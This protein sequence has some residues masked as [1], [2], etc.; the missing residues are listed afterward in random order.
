MK[1]TIFGIA[2]A[3][4][5]SACVSTQHRAAADPA[6]SAQAF[7]MLKSLA[8]SWSGTSKMGEQTTT[9]DVSYEVVSAGSVVMERLFVGTPHEMISMYHRDGGRLLMTHYCSQGNQPRMELDSFTQSPETMASFS[10]LDAT[11]WK[12]PSELVMHN[13][14]LYPIGKDQ[15]G[16][17]WVAWVNGKPDHTANF[18]FSRA[19]NVLG[20]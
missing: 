17:D 3:L 7:E 10:F 4:L 1:S 13:V 19:L 9:V 2:S 11:N 16:A 5:L 14:R 8:G 12:S 15:L 18:T 20:Y 6:E